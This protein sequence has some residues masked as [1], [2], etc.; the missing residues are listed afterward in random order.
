MDVKVLDGGLATELERAGIS[1]NDDPL[2]S[3]RVLLTNPAAVKNVHT[4]FLESGADIIETGTYQASIDGL[5]Q[6]A[7][8]S[9]DKSIELM[10]AAV[11]LAQD[12][13]DEY[14]QSNSKQGIEKPQV[15]GS[16]GPYGACQH[17]A[18][19]YHGKYVD[20]MSF[21][22]LQNWHRPRIQALVNAGVD[23]LA[24]ETIPAGK[25]AK[26]IVELLANEFSSVKAFL[27]F[28]CKDEQ[29]TCYGDMFSAAVSSISHCEQLIA[30]GVN[31]CAPRYITPL[32]KQARE[33]SNYKG[34]YVS[35]PN[36]GEQWI[37]SGWSGEGEKMNFQSLIPEWIQLGARY[38]GGCCRTSPDDV[39][40]I[41]E[42][43]KT[44][45]T[46]CATKR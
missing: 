17:D 37:D 20:S 42:L 13:V 35:C 5:S 22:D 1:I 10:T 45:R 16:V 15:S 38:I 14:W 2:W 36:S 24:I 34:P 29:H 25:E 43:V 44:Y 21:Q 19:E 41:A 31:C 23:L 4:S 33:H 30:I 3:A 11:K 12:A 32:L 26:A 18:S 39:Y 40:T 7:G 28:S 27:T 8:M 46:Q 6:H 9:A